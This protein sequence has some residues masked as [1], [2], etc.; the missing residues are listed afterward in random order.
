MKKS[1]LFICTHNAARSQLAEG[2]L[3]A[4]YRDQYN[5]FSA[6]LELGEVNPYVITAMADG[7]IDLSHHRSKSLNEFRGKQFDVVVTVCDHAREACPF[8]PGKMVLH[9]SF[10]DPSRL[11]GSE[12]DILREVRRIC[13]AIR[14]WVTA[15]FKP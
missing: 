13:D 15:T 2:F 9:K 12:D 6:G 4:L 14:D 11:K 7:G 3:K 5:A 1:A 10:P 8:F